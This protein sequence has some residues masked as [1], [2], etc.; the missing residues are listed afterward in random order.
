MVLIAGGVAWYAHAAAQHRRLQQYQQQLKDSEQARQELE[1][2]LAR[3]MRRLDILLSTMSEAVLLVDRDCRVIVANPVARKMF[4]MAETAEDRPR[5][6]V[7]FYR[8]PDWNQVLARAMAGATEAQDLPDMI[9][10][11][12]VLAPRLAPIGPE[13]ALLVCLD[14]T[15]RSKL[16]KQRDDFLANL[17]HDLKTPLTSMLG[18]ARSLAS[19]GE[20]AEF[21]R[22]AGE[23][24][25]T[26]AKRVN[27]LLDALLT[28]DQIRFAPVDPEA[29]CDI[30]EVI[31]RVQGSTASA[32]AAK[33]V[34]FIARVPEAGMPA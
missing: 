34:R 13:Q 3:R 16:A 4:G 27:E 17:M 14:V 26:E 24:I 19:F 23:V 20:D 11:N 21:R 12:H 6:M 33:G 31:A 29:H 2:R 7:W 5:P 22:M 1:G 28:L 9:L 8:D 18:Y 10:D 30:S 32:A 25:A 15:E